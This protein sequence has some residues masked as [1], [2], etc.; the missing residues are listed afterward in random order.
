MKKKAFTLAEVLITLV[1]IGVIAAITIPSLLNKTNQQEYRVGAKKAYSVLSQAAQHYYADTGQT[2][3]IWKTNVDLILILAVIMII[4]I[5]NT[6]ILLLLKI[7]MKHL[8]MFI[9][10]TL[11]VIT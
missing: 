1:I 4:F 3:K 5:L 11:T 7:P 9:R 10:N 2:M 6:L 8:R